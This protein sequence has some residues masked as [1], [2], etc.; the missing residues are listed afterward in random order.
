[1]P[2]DEW[3]LQ[4]QRGEKGGVRVGSNSARISSI[5]VKHGEMSM[6][7]TEYLPSLLD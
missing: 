3:E 5:R 2:V 1:M 6:V 4:G 7:L